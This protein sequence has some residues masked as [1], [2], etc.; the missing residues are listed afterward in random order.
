ME[1]SESMFLGTL[2]LL[3]CASCSLATPQQA[4]QSS[5]TPSTMPTPTSMVSQLPEEPEGTPSQLP[6]RLWAFTSLQQVNSQRFSYA[7][8]EQDAAVLR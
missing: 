1:R 6:E 3:L 8:G 7:Q 4:E 5:T 2:A